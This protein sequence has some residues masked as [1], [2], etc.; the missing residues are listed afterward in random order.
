MINRIRAKIV[1]GC[2]VVVV[3]VVSV[4]KVVRVINVKTGFKMYHHLIMVSLF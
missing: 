3:E 2:V 1:K 4:I